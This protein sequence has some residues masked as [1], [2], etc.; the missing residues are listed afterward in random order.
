MDRA[1]HLAWAKDRALAYLDTEQPDV[2]LTSLYSDLGKHPDLASHPAI[3]LGAMQQ[4]A[5]QLS[6]H[7][8]IRH[9]IEGVH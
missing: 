5:G 7:A 4:Q 8:S 3:L 2:G 1:E 6:D 9:F